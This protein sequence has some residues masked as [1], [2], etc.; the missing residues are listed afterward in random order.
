MTL[1]AATEGQR[2]IRL[3]IGEVAQ[4]SQAEV[5][6]DEQ[7]RMSSGRLLEREQYRSLQTDREQV[8][9][10]HLDPP[11][12]LGIDRILVNFEV[13]ERRM[14]LATVRDLLAE[15]LLVERGAIAKLE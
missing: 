2:E 1:Q 8:C 4:I 5:T 10:A 14:L 12:Q 11:G 3:D 13:D 15:K 6:F 9:V 7:G